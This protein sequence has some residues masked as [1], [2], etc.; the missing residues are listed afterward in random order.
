MTKHY[1]NPPELYPSLQYGFSQIVTSPPGRMLFL[2]GQV[3]WDE[4]QQLVG[5]SDLKAQ[6][7][8]IFQNLETALSV[9]G[10]GLS[11]I[12][13]MR[14]YMVDYKP[15]QSSAISDVLA[16]VFKGQNPPACTW[17]GVASLANPDFLAE[18]EATAVVEPG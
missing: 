5:G 13:A 2:S 16:A 11:D 12:V 1:L 10:S 6:L 3:A 8:Q 9:A 14:L 15:S 4:R 18:V 7:V 17:I